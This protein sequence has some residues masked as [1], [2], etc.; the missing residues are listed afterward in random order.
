MPDIQVGSAAHEIA[1]FQPVRPHLVVLGA[2]AML[3][4]GTAIE[5]GFKVCEGNRVLAVR[6]HSNPISFCFPLPPKTIHSTLLS[7]KHGR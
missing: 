5:I 1:D 4:M 3:R 2:G 6:I 7:R